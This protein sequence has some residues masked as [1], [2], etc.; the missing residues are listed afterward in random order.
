MQLI[1]TL[2]LNF[3]NTGC[4]KYIPGTYKALRRLGCTWSTLSRGGGTPSTRSSFHG[5]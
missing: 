1:A 5:P 3:S 2:K 4:L